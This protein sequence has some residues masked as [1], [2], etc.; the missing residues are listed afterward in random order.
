MNKN[1][2]QRAEP[3]RQCAE[4]DNRL[5]SYAIGERPELINEDPYGGGWLVRIK[6][7]D[8]SEPDQLMDADG[9]RKLLEDS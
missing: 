5:A 3:K 2:C 8:P 6:L 1:R 4:H 9:Y 7:S